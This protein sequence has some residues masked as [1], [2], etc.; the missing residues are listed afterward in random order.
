MRRI[1]FDE[2]LFRNMWADPRMPATAIGEALGM[3]PHTARNAA[4]RLGLPAK[5]DCGAKRPRG[6]RFEAEAKPKPARVTPVA[7]GCPVDERLRLSNGR[8]SVLA[9]IAQDYGW[10]NAETMRRYHMAVRS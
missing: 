8:Y 5:T 9:A 2:A 6:Y 4:K 1:E 10:T 7:N 3:S